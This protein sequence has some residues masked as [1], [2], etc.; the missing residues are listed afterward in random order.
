[1]QDYKY[2]NTPMGQAFTKASVP[3]E[4][5]GAL[6]IGIAPDDEDVIT[7][8]FKSVALPG[9]K[10]MGYMT[11]DRETGR[12]RYDIDITRKGKPS[13][14]ISSGWMDFVFPDGTDYSASVGK[15][16]DSLNK[17]DSNDTLTETDWALFQD[18]VGKTIEEMNKIGI[19]RE[20]PAPPGQKKPKPGRPESIIENPPKVV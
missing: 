9:K 16:I 10:I 8:R 1:M 19:P 17:D 5:E 6:L 18:F 13:N 2:A 11:Y 15:V 20:R 12:I 4:E 3:P 7:R 14:A